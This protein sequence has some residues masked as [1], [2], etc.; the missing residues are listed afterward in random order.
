V[1]GG[2]EEES[3]ILRDEGDVQSQDTYKT[4]REFRNERETVAFVVAP[5]VFG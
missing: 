4:Q 1:E 5:L 2:D 3:S